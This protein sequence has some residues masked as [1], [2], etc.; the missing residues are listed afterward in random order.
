M[1]WNLWTL[2]I[3][4]YRLYEE[5]VSDIFQCINHL[6]DFEICHEEEWEE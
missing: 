2:K 3:Y 1:F 6:Y 5:T 4:D